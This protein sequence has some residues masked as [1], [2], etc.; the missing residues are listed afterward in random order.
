MPRVAIATT[1]SLAADGA[2][3]I[4]DRGGNAVDAALTAALV[5]M[6]TE[7]G[8]CALAGGAFITVWA[9]GEAP[10]TCDGYVTVPGLGTD[11]QARDDAALD[12]TMAYGGGI[13][14]TIG[15]ASVAVPGTLAA[16]DT[17]MDRYGTLGLAAVL[18]PSIAAARD[19]FPLSQA[20]HYYLQYSGKSVFG[21]DPVSLRALHPDGETLLPAG[22]IVHLPGLANSLQAI[23]ANGAREFYEGELARTIVDHVVAGGG[24]LTREDMARFEAVLRPSLQVELG[25]WQIALNPPPAIGGTMLGALLLATAN[26][27]PL[28]DALRTALQYRRGALDFADALEPACQALIDQA[29]TDGLRTAVRGS[30]NTVHT[31][32]V[33]SNGLACAVTA[34]SG[35]GSGEMPAGTGLWLNNCL[36]ELELN[37]RGLDAGPPGSRLP[38]N[39][40]PTAARRGDDAL[41]IGSPGAD[42]ITSALA[43]V[44]T[45]FVLENEPLQQAIDAPRFHVEAGLTRET[46]ESRFPE[47][48]FTE[49]GALGVVSDIEAQQAFDAPSMY[50]GGAGGTLFDA[51][52]DTLTAAADPR[53]TGATVVTGTD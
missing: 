23:A 48:L 14:T 51:A 20:C 6:N 24:V 11:Q 18:E 29:R 21:R 15:P 30:A 8:V 49:P 17:V 40:A 38:S 28:L 31:S 34:S 1:S 26:G 37:R 39:M 7:P 41:A 43:Q 36:G 19:G 27:T 53:R 50:F 4:I 22:G 5:T 46:R 2:R 13:T 3:D 10:V 25:D 16:V 32:A 12:V 52:G 42:R 35:Y 33:D 44:L 47:R 9:P 45:R